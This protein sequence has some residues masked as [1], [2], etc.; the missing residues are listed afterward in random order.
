M[1]AMS[2]KVFFID[3]LNLHYV[4]VG[5]TRK[6]T[7]FPVEHR[8]NFYLYNYDLLIIFF[9]GSG[10]IY[11]VIHSIFHGIEFLIYNC[12][13]LPSQA[14]LVAN[15]LLGLRAILSPKGFYKY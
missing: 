15:L 14:V 8:N 1:Y 5:Y 3:F 12:N 6:F 10:S 4:R 11:S 7:G 13:K 2:S 9:V